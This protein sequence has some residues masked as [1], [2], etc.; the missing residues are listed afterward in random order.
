[1]ARSRTHDAPSPADT[2]DRD[3]WHTWVYGGAAHPMND[4]VD[5]SRIR[6]AYAQEEARERARSSANKKPAG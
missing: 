4:P 3:D 1:M 5:W 6:K 2:Y